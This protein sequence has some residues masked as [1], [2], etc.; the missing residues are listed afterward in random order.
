MQGTIL[1]PGG[2]LDIGTYAGFESDV[3][4]AIEAGTPWLVL[5]FSEVVYLGTLGVRVVMTAMKRLRAAG[6][7]LVICAM[8]TPVA[9]VIE[10][11]GLT[12]LLEIYPDRASALAALS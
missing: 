1:Q 2:R 10:I 4:A 11:S 9:D 8:Q 12:G 6:G 3:L 5:D 7:R